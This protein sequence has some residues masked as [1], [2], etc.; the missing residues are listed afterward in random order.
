MFIRTQL[1]FIDIKQGRKRLK[2]Y[3]YCLKAVSKYAN[4]VLKKKE[5]EKGDK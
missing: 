2:G 5:K 1:G 3:L 4:R